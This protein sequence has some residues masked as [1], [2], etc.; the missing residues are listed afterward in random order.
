MLEYG[1][2]QPHILDY[3]L[4]LERQL[5]GQIAL[6]V[7]YAGSRGL[8]L[9]QIKEGNPVVPEIVD[10]RKFWPASQPVPAPRPACSFQRTN[11]NWCSMEVHTAGSNSWYNSMQFTLSKQL[12]HGLQF[13]SSYT[14]SKLLDETQG[15]AGADNVV[16]NVAGMDPSNRRADKGPADFDLRQNWQFNTIYQL[17][18][19]FTGRALST[20]L[21]GWRASSI[22]S[23]QSGFPFTPS[24]QTNRSRSGV[25]V[26]QA[27]TQSANVDHPDLLPGR[28]KDN[29]ILGGPDRYF[30]SSAFALQ[31]TGFLGT[32]GR[33]FLTGP[34]FFNL[35][36]ALH[37]TT[38]LRKLGESTALEFRAEFFN[39]LNHANFSLSDVF[40]QIFAGADPPP[41]VTAAP[42]AAAGRITTTGQ[43]RSRQIQ[44]ALRLEF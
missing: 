28:N 24:V 15:Q 43:S 32:S 38:P 14:W 35:D 41:G 34:G 40:R 37:K 10:G 19:P 3:N 36:F 11:P 13:Q 23:V 18:Q 22:L 7:G 5:P 16:S 8:N 6:T 27:V 29:I 2:E 44:F 20:L 4:T 17:P 25:M 42:L 9:M 39:I 33:N 31:P 26:G 1:L 12:S 30:D 21:N